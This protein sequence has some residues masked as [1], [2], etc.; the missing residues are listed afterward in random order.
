MNI[1]QA[2]QVLQPGPLPSLSHVRQRDVADRILVEWLRGPVR[3]AYR[4]ACRRLHP[5]RGPAEEVEART[6]AMK[7]INEAYRVLRTELRVVRQQPRP[8]QHTTFVQSPFTNTTTTPITNPS[9][10]NNIQWF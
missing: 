3:N 10:T 4:R 5:D 9:I 1:D 7:Q 8:V 6:T 2:M